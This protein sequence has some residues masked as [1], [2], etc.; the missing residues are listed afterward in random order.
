[1]TYYKETHKIIAQLMRT[2][3]MPV[4]KEMKSHIESVHDVLPSIST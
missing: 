4:R 2:E 1:M 3:K